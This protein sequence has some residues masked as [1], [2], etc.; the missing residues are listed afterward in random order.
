[1][2]TPLEEVLHTISLLQFNNPQDEAIVIKAINQ[3]IETEKKVIMD[4]FCDGHRNGAKPHR[5]VQAIDYYNEI[6][7]LPKTTPI[8]RRSFTTNLG[9][10]R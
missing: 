2:R 6:F 8:R 4:A 9:L 10:S 3:Q 7:D 5:K 1:M